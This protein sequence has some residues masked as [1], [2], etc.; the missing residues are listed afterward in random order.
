VSFFA[1]LKRRN[2]IRMAIA[3]SLIA[4]VVLQVLDVVVGVIDAPAWVLQLAFFIAAIG[5]LAVLII[6]WVYEMTPEGVKKE[7]D[8]DRSQSITS[9]TGRKLDRLIIVFLAVAVVFLLSE[10]FR[11]EAPSTETTTTATET[12]ADVPPVLQDQVTITPDN[13]S[14]AV[15]P[16][17]AMSSGE[18]DEYFADG[19]TEEIL[20]SL[21]QLPELL[22][23]ARTSAFSFKGQ[24]LPVNE[25]AD[26][27]GVK[28]IVEGSV[29]RSGD[30]IRV[31]AQLVRAEDGFHLW[32]DNYDST[33]ED[34]IQVQEDIAEQIAVTLN[35][36]LDDSKRQAMQLA[37][38]RNVEAFTKYQKARYYYMA[39]HGE[40]E[41]V[42]ALR[43]ANTLFE[44]VMELVPE[45][46][47]AYVDHSDLFAH[48][49]LDDLAGFPRPNVTQEDVDTAMDRA[50]HDY[51]MAIQ[52]AR[53][54]RE[55][56][57]YEYDR[58]FLA[59]EWQGIPGRVHMMLNEQGCINN[60]WLAQFAS[61]YGFAEDYVSFAHEMRVCDPLVSIEWFNESR[62]LFWAG[63]K[64]EALAVAL[65]GSEVAPG[66]WINLQ[67]VWILVALGRFEEADRVV[68]TRMRGDGDITVSRMMI[69]AG[70]G[71]RD[72]MTRQYQLYQEAEGSRMWTFF[73]LVWSGQRELAN[74]LVAELDQ[75][76][77]NHFA[78]TVFS[79]WCACGAP[80]DLEA[81]PNFAAKLE[82]SGLTWPP[83]TPVHFPLK[84]W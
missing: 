33:S 31:T 32:S 82:E 79:S 20:N 80:F 49:Q 9:S 28:H 11:T 43:T 19:L 65:E 13:R 46:S 55:R 77:N 69:A 35:V 84:D 38:L 83:P 41:T 54:D 22:V 29:R 24:D 26:K 16:F 45:F 57:S 70:R 36:V 76:P 37:G 2:V 56:H 58:A 5:L 62:A 66:G 52:Y 40:L 60:N 53:S 8:V 18:D 68:V 25:I 7:T 81:T 72:E 27:L 63:R 1:E 39:A 47:Q 23:T 75:A 3:Y 34:T 15:L 50:I 73:Y 78:F 51:D 59:G 30:R 64:E 44:E 4:W 10:R 6:S 67:T 71:D 74:E 21:A 12:E 14:L 61:V 17:V 48:Y 42:E